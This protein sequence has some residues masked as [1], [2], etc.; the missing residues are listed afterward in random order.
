MHFI[1]HWTLLTVTLIHKVFAGEG[2]YELD[3]GWDDFCLDHKNHG[4]QSPVDL[5]FRNESSFKHGPLGPVFF[6]GY[7]SNKT[8]N[9][10][11]KN[12]G[13]DFKVAFPELRASI[14]SFIFELTYSG[15]VEYVLDS[16]HFH[17]GDKDHEGSE[18]T[19]NGT[20]LDM[21]MHMVHKSNYDGTEQFAVVSKLFNVTQDPDLDK[22]EL[23]ESILDIASKNV[24]EVD[25]HSTGTLNITQERAKEFFGID[26]DYERLEGY[27]T[28]HGSLTTHPCTET[29]TWIIQNKLQKIKESNME[30]F[31]SILKN[32][33]FTGTENHRKTQ[34]LNGRIIKCNNNNPNSSGNK[35]LLHGVFRS[36]WIIWSMFSIFAS[37]SLFM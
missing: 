22:D 12:N 17:W 7:Y 1:I 8:Q 13:Y 30:K 10:F 5:D 34:P 14:S 18:H 20:S 19:L 2:H 3:K 32:A 36:F 23:L 11:L 26:G 27:C 24:K 9:I 16:V 31:R 21:E 25:S 29:V 37:N 28:Y 33:Q 4:H 6:M 15:P 35:Q